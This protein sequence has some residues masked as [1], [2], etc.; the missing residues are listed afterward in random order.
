MATTIQASGDTIK[1]DK[2]FVSGKDRVAVNGDVVFEGKLRGEKPQQ[3]VVG[4]RKY[5]IRT[6][7][8]SEVTGAIVVQLKIYEKT[9]AIHTGMY[10]Q[11]GKPVGSEAEATTAPAIQTAGTL[12]AAIGVGT[13]LVLNLV[14]GSVP[15]G[16][17]G[18]ALGGALGGVIGSG[19]GYLLYR[20]K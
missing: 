12:G 9:G 15:G 5:A 3:F 18:G 8:V 20:D 4:H 1:I 19:V 17:I 13:M 11:D 2:A 7:L 16:A 14:T 6:K 10:D